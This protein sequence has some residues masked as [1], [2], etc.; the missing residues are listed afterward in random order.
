MSTPTAR[1]VLRLYRNLLRYGEQLKFTD[2]KYYTG[3]IRTEF[4]KNKT[5]KSAEDIEFNFKVRFIFELNFLIRVRDFDPMCP[6]FFSFGRKEK[7]F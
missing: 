6:L 7:P 3:R 4:S 5:L 1:E 2:V